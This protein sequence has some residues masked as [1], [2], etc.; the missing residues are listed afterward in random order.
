[1]KTCLRIVGAVM[2]LGL[3]AADTPT[4][5]FTHPKAVTA[6]NRYQYRA[7][8]A[9]EAFEREMASI[10]A[11]YM[12]ALSEAAQVVAKTGD[13]EELRRIAE[14]QD[15]ERRGD[16]VSSPTR[17]L[18]AGTAWT[19]DDNSRVEY[20]A[21]GSVIR[22][23]DAGRSPGVWRVQPN[24]SV[25]VRFP[26][27]ASPYWVITPDA[28]GRHYLCV[29]YAPDERTVVAATAHKLLGKL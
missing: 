8:K 28:E 22:T 9:R 19:F 7:N 1:M 25:Q 27:G 21:D 11:E 29:R 14:V 5:P 6:W 10:R 26:T 15:A 18:L 24:G 16:V 3:V 4:A 17:A 13:A 12:A 2:L 20:R 23:N